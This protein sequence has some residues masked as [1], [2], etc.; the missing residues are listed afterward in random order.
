MSY[1][2]ASAFGMLCRTG[3]ATVEE[4]LAWDGTWSVS[5]VAHMLPI[6][7]EIEAEQAKNQFAAVSAAIAGCFAK[8]GAKPFLEGLDRVKREVKDAGP[9]SEPMKGRARSSSGSTA[10]KMLGMLKSLGVPVAKA[11]RKKGK[12]HA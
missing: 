1:T 10:D 9:R 3:L 12:S 5:L 2:I 8:G 11:T 6:A 7:V 4:L